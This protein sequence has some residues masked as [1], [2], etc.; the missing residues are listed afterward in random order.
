MIKS[1]V[2]FCLGILEQVNI[3]G[4]SELKGSA[5]DFIIHCLSNSLISEKEKIICV[6]KLALFNCWD[7]W[8]MCMHDQ[9]AA[10]TCSLTHVRRALS[11]G[12]NCKRHVEVLVA[13]VTVAKEHKELL[14]NIIS[15]VGANVFEIFKQYGTRQEQKDRILLCANCMKFIMLTY[16]FLLSRNGDDV[17]SEHAFISTVFEVLVDIVSHNG[18]PNQNATALPGADPALGRMSAQFFVHVL[19]TSPAT[20]KACVG[21]MS[22]E[23]RSIFEKSVRADMSGYPSTAPTKKR[24]NFKSFKQ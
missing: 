6:D 10:A 8:Q 12:K 2:G 22:Q 4:C 17:S 23:T 13:I 19:R 20:F 1:L 14:P 7:A 3:A 18:L 11:D 21:S 5:Q 15:S 9:M 24:L 16:Q